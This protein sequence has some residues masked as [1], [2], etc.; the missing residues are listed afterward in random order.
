M[1]WEGCPWGEQIH[2][3]T[4]VLSRHKKAEMGVACEHAGA[5]PALPGSH[6]S[7]LIVGWVTIQKPASVY[8]AVD[9]T[10]ESLIHTPSSWLIH[11][12]P[13]SSVP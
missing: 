11:L 6:K 8:P 9:R 13:S 4:Q 2:R 3:S 1:V 10:T 5:P 12:W 7:L